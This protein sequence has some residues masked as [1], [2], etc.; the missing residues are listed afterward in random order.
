MDFGGS[1]METNSSPKT[2]W[3][4]GTIL[5]LILA[6][7][8]VG[9]FIYS[10]NRYNEE[11]EASEELR[12]EVSMLGATQAKLEKSV[13][14]LDLLPPLAGADWEKVLTD[15]IN[16][17]AVQ[18]GVRILSLTYTSQSDGT[19]GGLGRISFTLEVEGN[20]VAQARC[21]ALLEQSV[22]GMGFESVAGA[23]GGGDAY[24]LQM[25]R[26][27]TSDSMRVTGTVYRA[28]EGAS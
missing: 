11:L 22:V 20:D 8:G 24:Y 25:M 13:A 3:T 2:V 27:A 21:L 28:T 19:Q 5:L 16:A 23:L 18:A 15:Q 6:L 14:H 26:D 9:V 10:T 1:T 17:A 7:V 4:A 12:M